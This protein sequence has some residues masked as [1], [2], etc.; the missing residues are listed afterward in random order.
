MHVDGAGQADGLVDHRPADQLVPPAAAA[1]PQHHLGGVLRVGELH[2]RHGDVRAGDLVVLPAEALQQA[3]VLVEGA[4]G[5]AGEALGAAHVQA[6]Q[7]A[8]GPLGEAGGPAD[9]H[10]AGRRPGERHHDP[11]AR[12]P[13]LGDAVAAAVLLQPHVDL[14]GDPQQ[15]QLAQGGEVPGPEVVAE[16]GVDLVGRVHVAVRHAPPQRLG[17]HVDELDLVGGPHHAVGH[18]LALGGAGDALD[19]VVGRLEVLDV[20]GGHDVDAGGEQ[21]VDVLPALLVAATGGVGVGHLVDQRDLGAPLE[22][23][24]D[25]HLLQRRAPVGDAPAGHHLQVADLLGRAFPAVRLD[26]AD[27]DVGAAF[28]APAALGQHGE[29]LAHAGRGAE[30]DAQRPPAG[31]GGAVGGG[32]G[33]VHRVAATRGGRRPATGAGT[34]SRG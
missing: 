12:L 22:D 4:R 5:R 7:L 10:L 23:G 27:H 11:L 6:Q 3:A 34:R 17:R 20:E 26:Q 16:G 31:P 24:V 2:Q 8:V 9:Q 14:V 21:L 25:V 29:R 32:G 33:A 28:G 18:G 15:R 30:V 13:R 1:G 19:H